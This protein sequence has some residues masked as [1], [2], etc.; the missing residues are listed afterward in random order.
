MEDVND[1]T[2]LVCLFHHRDQAEAALKDLLKA[3]I[4]EP[5]IS[6]FD[7]SDPKSLQRGELQ[8]LGIPGRDL[9][10]LEQGL[11][12]GGVL[13]VVSAVAN[14][15]SRVEEIFG[16]HRATKIDEAEAKG[17][18]VPLAAAA[19]ATTAGTTAIP[20]VEEELA[21][22]K[23]TVDQ[24]GVRVYRRVVEIPVEESVS[25]REEHINVTRHP[26]DRAVTDADLALQGDRTI[27]LTETAEE[28]VVGKNARVVEEVLVGKTATERT[29]HIHDSVRRTEVEVDE[30]APETGRDALTKKF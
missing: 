19:S 5:S 1:L 2:T 17:Q 3:G 25:L 22:G 15:A 23:R 14:H 26:V 9:Q 4:P 29:E 28:A 21:V 7:E 16:A 6:V 10:H 30:I 27:E 18:N 12:D 13:V 24:G 20:I 8:T 11:R